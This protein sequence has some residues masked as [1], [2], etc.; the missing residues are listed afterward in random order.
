MGFNSGFKGLNLGASTCW[1]PLGL[2]RPVM[3]LLYLF[4]SYQVCYDSQCGTKQRVLW[5]RKHITGVTWR[6][7]AL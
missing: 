3:A 5:D 2:S 7:A 1:N 4:I 6:Q